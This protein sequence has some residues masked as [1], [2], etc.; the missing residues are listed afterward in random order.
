MSLLDNAPFAA[1]DPQARELLTALLT[2][3]DQGAEV[4]AFV[5]AA[6]MRAAEFA[7][8]APMAEVWPQVLRRAADQGRLRRLVGLIAEDPNSAA[9]GIIARLA[10]T[11]TGAISAA[12]APLSYQPG[13]VRRLVMDA[14]DDDELNALC[15]DHF[16]SVYGQFAQGMSK[17]QK[18]LRLIEY[19]ARR[20]RLPDLVGRVGEVNPVRH[21]EFTDRLENRDER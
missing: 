20:D 1:D 5:L 7:W 4:R 13:D 11:P 2:A 21:R 17:S 8:T 6:G 18:T 10:A 15:L 12:S 19:C 9:Y 16:P 14:L 3:Y